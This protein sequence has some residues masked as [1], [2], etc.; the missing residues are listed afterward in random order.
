MV[1]ESCGDDIRFDAGLQGVKSDTA[2]HLQEVQNSTHLLIRRKINL[3]D[4]HRRVSL[5]F[6]KS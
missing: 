2:Q 6:N 4:Q 3:N 5:S 1:P